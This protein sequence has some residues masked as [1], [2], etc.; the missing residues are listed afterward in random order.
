MVAAVQSLERWMLDSELGAFSKEIRRLVLTQSMRAGVG[1]IGSALSITDIIATLFEAVMV[2]PANSLGVRDR[3]VLSKGHA[4]LALYAALYLKGVITHDQLNSY[5]MD[6]SLVGVHPEHALEGVDFTTS[7]LGQGLSFG[8]GSA[9]AAR[10]RGETWRSFVLMSDAECNEGSTW[11]AV[12]FAAHQRLSNLVAIVDL[13]GQQALGY[14]KDVLDLPDMGRR[15]Q[16]FGWD[17]HVVDGHD[18]ESMSKVLQ[19]LDYDNGLPH[20]LIANTTFGKGVSFMESEI[21][22]HYLPMNNE[23]FRRAMCEVEVLG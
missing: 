1:H 18:S 13:N 14:T 22:R 19:S 3:F 6:G 4:A 9:L 5:C 7:S 23:Q 20:V 10:L 21:R 12:M 17:V 11:E 16:A 2:V 8:T 15:W